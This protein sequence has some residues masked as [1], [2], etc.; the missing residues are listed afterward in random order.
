MMMN[1]AARPSLGQ[2][3]PL[4]QL[5]QG[6]M[7]RV[8][9]VAREGPANIQKLLVV[10]EIREELAND[11]EFVTMFMDE[12]RIATRMSHPNV[13]QTYEV[14]AEGPHYFMVMEYL[15]GQPM[16]AVLGRIKRKLPLPVHMRIM[17]RVLAGLH[18]A[19]ELCAFD[20]TPLQVVH[21][22]VSPQNTILCYD[23]QVKLVDFGIAKAAGVASRTIAGK[24]KGKLGYVAPEQI[25][26]GDIDRRADV[27]SAGVMLWEALVGRRLTYGENEA[28][29][30]YKRTS[31]TQARVLEARPEA[32]RELA[33]ICDRAME[34]DPANRFPTALDM[35]NALESRTD[36]LDTR[37]SDGDIGRLVSDAFA[38]ERKGI[39]A[40][41]ERQLSLPA[42]SAADA[43]AVAKLPLVASETGPNS[44][45]PPAGPWTPVSPSNAP[46]T[47]AGT[48]TSVPLDVPAFRTSK[49]VVVL[50]ASAG[51]IIIGAVIAIATVLGK[52]T[53]LPSHASATA[54]SQP[55]APSVTAAP[56]E[57]TVD[58]AIEVVPA[59]AKI[60]IDGKNVGKSPFRA[61]VQ[62]DTAPH[63]IVASADGYSTET[64]A[65]GFDRDVRVELS[66][67]PVALGGRVTTS[68]PATSG[69][70]AG[71]DLQVT[72]PKHNID[73][74]DPY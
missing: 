54:S 30:L 74:K 57:T 53:P 9:L 28:S 63:E 50:V 45:Q 62:K 65:I 25:A 13:V 51:V 61:A 35:L 5:G 10:K 15:E 1:E 41:V 29:V 36:M 3:R 46:P 68:A 26:G 67:R 58:V 66:L 8:L 37:A 27:F 17:G 33:A 12:A 69:G 6:G 32:D 60:L 73:E 42:R 7:A 38:E 18:Y 59:R 44:I 40:I 71:S 52:T 2:Y 21:R 4:A 49:R 39:L 23:G 19:H 72:R 24:F 20:G 70:S 55:P 43:S 22:D 56:V 34:L 14:G 48:S 16:H 11:A 31:G 47:I 64:R